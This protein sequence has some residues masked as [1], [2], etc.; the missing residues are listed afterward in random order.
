MGSKIAAFRAHMMRKM[1]AFHLRVSFFSCVVFLLS[2]L[3]VWNVPSAFSADGETGLFPKNATILFQGDS[4]TD[5][6]R[7]RNLD[8]NH[9]LGHGYQFIIASRLGALN[10]E[11][12]WK[13]LNRGV[14][15]DTVQSMR[16]RWDK[17]T[18]ELKPD[19]LSILIGVNDYWRGSSAEEYR[20]DFDELLAYTKEKLP[21]VKLIIIEPFATRKSTKKPEADIADYQVASRDLAKKYGAVYVPT[22]EMF[23]EHIAAQPEDNYW[24]WDGVH[25]T[26]NGH[27][28]LY[29]AWI[30]ALMN[31]K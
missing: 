28:L 2:A 3:S 20:A 24:I 4:I 26:Y 31:A 12:N 22:Q 15:G 1:S 23:S 17:D 5:G 13:F 27:W 25:P 6:N 30:D 10:S 21:N 14:S 16:A 8:P 18:I 9:I 11:M 7:G 19:V 29:E